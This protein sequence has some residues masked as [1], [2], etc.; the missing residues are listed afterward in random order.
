MIGERQRLIV[1][2]DIAG[3]LEN[4]DIQSM[5]RL[6]LYADGIDLE[7]LIAVTSCWQRRGG[8]PK[9]AAFI[10]R[11]IDRYEAAL[12][13]LRRHSS[14]YPNAA[15]LRTL[16]TTGIPV[17][18]AGL[19]DGFGEA[20]FNDVPGVRLIIEALTS[21][22]P[23]PLWVA[24]WGGAN[25]LAQAIWALEQTVTSEELE[26]M[27][28]KLRVH[29]I[30]DQDAGGHWLRDRF[31]ERIFTIVSP[32]PTSG[33]KFYRFATWPGIAADTSSHG[34]EDGTTGGGFRGA[35]TALVSRRWIRRNIRRGAYGRGYPLHRF[36]MEGDTPS[37]LGLI[38]NGLNV[39][40]RPDL[41][42]WGGRYQYR[43]PTG[44]RGDR[45][46]TSAIWTDIADTVVGL[47]G[48][49][50]TSPQASIWRWR[51]HFQ[52]DFAGRIK[53]TLA[54]NY[55]GAN[56]PPTVQLSRADV[57]EVDA[58]D[59]VVFDASTSVDPD[60]DNLVF[61]WSQY[62]EPEDSSLVTVTADGPRCKVEFS[63]RAGGAVLH[64]LVAVTDDGTP[65]LTS[66][67][68]VTLRVQALN[69]AASDLQA[70]L[71]GPE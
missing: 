13:N 15:F 27:L 68:R 26:V 25:T 55:D 36:V 70:G 17:F 38:P 30:S 10:H 61:R 28:A 60:G 22:D 21:D 20:R 71:S 50:H 67:C 6:L 63:D 39:P 23:R 59:S 12:P 31:G 65:P 41:G 51:E 58:G 35:N 52:N 11:L 7:G 66:Y 8:K 16:V 3:G 45:R 69:S 5:A 19:G 43:T 34:S 57:L 37:F 9:N 62:P 24:L 47:D 54:P 42:G 49:T 33:D 1:L 48:E 29:A 32:S 4:D 44:L 2:T 40:E 56:H 53:W 64:L 18:G 14:G 46:E